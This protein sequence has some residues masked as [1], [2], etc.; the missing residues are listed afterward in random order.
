[1][2]KIGYSELPLSRELPDFI[3]TFAH[4]SFITSPNRT[5]SRD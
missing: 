4:I 5:A 1:M 2:D 3:F